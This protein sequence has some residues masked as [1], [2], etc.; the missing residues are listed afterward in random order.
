[1]HILEVLGELLVHLI[2]TSRFIACF[3][4]SVSVVGL[5]LAFAPVCTLRTICC[6]GIVC[7]GLG[8]GIFWECKS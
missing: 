7:L 8:G 1:M 3:L 6:I 5:I 4:L 2:G